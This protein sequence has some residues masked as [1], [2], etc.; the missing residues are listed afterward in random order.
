MAIITRKRNGV[1]YVYEEIYLGI[2]DGKRKY[3]SRCLGHLDESGELILSKKNRV[4][5]MKVLP[6]KI[7]VKTI[8][9]KYVIRP[10]KK[11]K[12]KDKIKLKK[13]NYKKR[14]CSENR[15][16]QSYS[17]AEFPD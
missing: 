4:R 13:L 2:K 9:V 10:R 8:T 6:A 1:K 17:V 12:I 3:K 11:N 14:S 5:A 7:V 15:N 16:Y